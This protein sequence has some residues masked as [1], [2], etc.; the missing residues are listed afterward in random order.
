MNSAARIAALHRPVPVAVP[1]RSP[2]PSRRALDGIRIGVLEARMGDTLSRLLER[3]GAR[4]V[5]APALVERPVADASLVADFCDALIENAYAAV[6]FQTGAGAA[7]LFDAIDGL[8][9]LDAARRA[10]EL[11]TTNCRGPKPA[12][13]LHAREIPIALT[14]REPWTTDECIEA[15]GTLALRG[16]RVALTHYGERNVRLA[17]AMIQAGSTLDELLLYEWSLPDDVSP[18]ERLVRA[19]A[20][21]ELDAVA[22]TSQ[23]QVRHLVEVATRSTREAALLAGLRRVV[24]AA[25]GPTCAAAVRAIGIEPAVVPDRPKMAPFVGALARHFEGKGSGRVSA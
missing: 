23:I 2:V 24:V 20:G 7:A 13:V 21:G 8:G 22:F 3:Q 12:A 5:Q 6:I 16:R 10:L 9:R 18:I 4:V 15:V 11:T 1:A 25:I 19:V 14:V 17:Q